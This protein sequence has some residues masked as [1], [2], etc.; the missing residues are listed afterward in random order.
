MRGKSV[1]E[2]F[3]TKTGKSEAKEEKI[4]ILDFKKYEHGR[5]IV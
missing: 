3:F 4:G 5:K 1:G 2:D